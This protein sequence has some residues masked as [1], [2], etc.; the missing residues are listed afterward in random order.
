MTEP[1][2]PP[3]ASAIG[4]VAAAALALALYLATLSPVQTWETMAQAARAAADPLLSERWFSTRLLHPNHLLYVPFA[5][6]VVLALGRLGLDGDRFL[7]LQISSACFGAGVA[8]FAGLLAL[9]LGTG[10]RRAALAALATGVSNA[11]WRLSTEIGAIVP[12]L[13]LLLVALWLAAGARRA[14]SWAGAG[15][16][17]AAAILVHQMVVMAAIA[18]SACVAVAAWRGRLRPA[19]AAAF[20]GTWTAL[21]FAGYMACG[22]I[23]GVARTP[24]EVLAWVL[25]VRSRSVFAEFSAVALARQALSGA[26]EAWVAL[27]PLRAAARGAWSPATAAGAAAALAGVAGAAWVAAR[28]LPGIAA[29]LRRGDL[30]TAS[31]A[32][33]AGA[34]VAFVIWYQPFNHVFWIFVP[35]LAAVLLARHAPPRAG[36]R[37][38]LAVVVLVAI[39]NLV[40]R[41][42]P[43]RDP[44]TAEYADL[45]A[46]AREH[47]VAGDV[48]VV[49]PAASSIGIGL[50]ALPTFARVE[51]L[52]LPLPE[53]APGQARF[54]RDVSARFEDARGASVFALREMA[55]RVR[56]VRPASV[57]R[58]VATLRG[59][60]L[61]RMVPTPP[62]A[63]PG[64]R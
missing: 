21:T 35:P 53:D 24:L 26:A 33:A 15:L 6:G 18:V 37:L 47:L 54:D 40:F 41:A 25:T 46:A 34:L 23:A 50:M 52:A 51:I 19:S 20:I 2:A 27:E 32:S 61:Y 42:L 56:R 29:A 49:D 55:E 14:R 48:L 8:L 17:L 36:A 22:W 45:L 64:N 28:A 31:I 7:P 3:P 59:D 12:G 10:A 57:P 43:A 4:V 11:V 5:R 44:S 16:A 39:V 1:E 63:P 60:T 9:R 58:A 30:A 62:I 13:L 38:G